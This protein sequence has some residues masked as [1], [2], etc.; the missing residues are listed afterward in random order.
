MSLHYYM[1]KIVNPFSYLNT[2]CLT[3]SLSPL[4][5]AISHQPS[6]IRLHPSYFI[7]DKEPFLLCT[8]RKWFY[9]LNSQSK[10]IDD[11]IEH[12]DTRNDN[13]ILNL[14]DI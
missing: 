13:A 10:G 6:Y 8:L 5:S 11:T 1:Q 3:S 12:A 7:K 14:R 2:A 9:H 4:P